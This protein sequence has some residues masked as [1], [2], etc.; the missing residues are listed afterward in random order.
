MMPREIVPWLYNGHVKI[1]WVILEWPRM[2]FF[3]SK[4]VSTL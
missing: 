2:F 4:P 1:E 3:A